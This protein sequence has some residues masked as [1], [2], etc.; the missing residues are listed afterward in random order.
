MCGCP[1]Y[2]GHGSTFVRNDS[3]VIIM[4]TSTQQSDVHCIET[5]LCHRYL[6]IVPK[7]VEIFSERK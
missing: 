3:K 4:N 5:L 6:G 7:N 1:I 2:P